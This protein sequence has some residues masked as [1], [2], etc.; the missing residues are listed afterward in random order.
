[1]AALLGTTEKIVRIICRGQ[2]YEK[3]YLNPR[4]QGPF[5]PITKNLETGLIK[6]Y[7]TSLDILADAGTL[8][9]KNTAQRTLEAVVHPEK[10]SGALSDIDEQENQLLCDVQVC[11]NRRSATADERLVC[12]IEIWNAPIK[13]ID[14]GINHL[15]EYT[16]EKERNEILKW[17]SSIPFGKNHNRVKENRTPG[18]GDWILRH[19]RFRDWKEN[20][21]SSLFW[22]QGSPGA[23]KT[24]LT[25]S[26]IDHI[27]DLLSD[28]PDHEGFAFFYCDRN[29]TLRTQ[30]LSVLQSFVRQLSTTER[31][32]ESIRVKLRQAYNLARSRGSDFQFVQCKEQILESLN[33]YPRTI[34]VIDAM[35]E[36]DSEKRYRLI[37]ALRT[38][39]LE[40]KNTVKIFISSRPDSN[41]KS[42][43]ASVPSVTIS[44]SDNH[45]DIEKFL[46]FE[47]DRLAKDEGIRVLGRMKTEIMAKLLEKCQGM[48]Q[49]A[50]MQIHQLKD[51]T[52]ATNVREMLKPLS[53]DLQKSYDKVWSQIEVLRESDQTLARR[54]L[55][56]TMTSLRP[57]ES[58]ELLLVIRI[59]QDGRVFAQDDSIE[60]DS[61]I[62]LCKNLIIFDT[63]SNVWRFAHISVLEYLESKPIGLHH[64]L[65][66]MLSM[67]VFLI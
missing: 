21:S 61:L 30:A 29:D 25:S 11:E 41:I 56:W 40:C 27:Q 6:I 53:D 14:E 18:T 35:D 9:S 33:I 49:W 32:P 45:D 13:H 4:A 22:L 10:A 23:G 66:I 64:G 31:S 54:A 51:C 60:E 59:G 46:D 43:L 34:L 48:F 55:R 39:I 58:R 24:F 16:Q 52:T 12:M 42:H 19:E 15:L 37:D 50:A 63:E 28:S 57:L 5:N 67:F 65:I 8:F 17:I 20:N 1:M 3:I 47:L 38:F 26:V 7:A 44:A 36:C 2:A 62:L